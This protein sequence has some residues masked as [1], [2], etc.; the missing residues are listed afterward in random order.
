MIPRTAKPCNIS[1]VAAEYACEPKVGGSLLVAMKNSFSKLLLL[2]VA[3]SLCATVYV[4]A[5]TLTPGSDPTFVST[6]GVRYRAFNRTSE[7][8]VY[9]GSGLSAAATRASANITYQY[10][11]NSNPFTIAYDSGL[12]QLSTTIGGQTSVWSW[13]PTTANAVRFG[14]QSFGATPGTPATVTVSNLKVNGSDVSGGPL[15][16]SSITAAVIS[17]SWTLTGLD[18]SSSFSLTGSLDLTAESSFSTS[19]EGSKVEF[20]FGNV[21]EVPEPSTWAAA[22]AVVAMVASQWRRRLAARH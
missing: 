16:V 2:V 10:E 22:G 3:L 11:P 21:S 14:L 7:Q 9:I 12:D 17:S 5:Q 18:F 6:V 13:S 15:S 1:A 4:C 19:A 8:E 20:Y